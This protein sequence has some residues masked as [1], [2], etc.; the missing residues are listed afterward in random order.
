MKLTS[1]P[2]CFEEELLISFKE[3]SFFHVEFS[4]WHTRVREG[5]SLKLNFVLLLGILQI[6]S[7]GSL[8]TMKSYF[9][10]C[11]RHCETSKQYLGTIIPRNAY[12]T[13]IGCWK[14]QRFLILWFYYLL[15]IYIYC[16]YLSENCISHTPLG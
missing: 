14:S 6:F 11:K 4:L 2:I 10:I 13:Q 3:P 1:I 12:C 8:V 16:T 15:A 9:T 7:V 5:W